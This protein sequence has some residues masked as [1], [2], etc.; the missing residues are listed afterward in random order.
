[1][2]RAIIRRWINEYLDGE[3]GLADKAE[4]E[5][6]MAENPE[7]HQEYKQL[8]RI[9]LYLSSIPDGSVHPT[10]FRLRMQK[11]LTRQEP[12][13]IT[14]QRAFAGAMVVALVV[15]A[16]TFG[17]MLYSQQ[18]A[19]IINPPAE[20]QVAAEQTYHLALDTG[21]TAEAFFNRLLL[22]SS[23]GMVDQSLVQPFLGQ[24]GVYEGAVCTQN[25]GMDCV[26]F[27]RKL[28]QTVKVR[29]TPRQALTLGK[30]AEGLTGREAGLA[31][32]DRDGAQVSLKD[33]I[34]F[35]GDNAVQLEMHFK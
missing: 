25:G 23:L 8:R 18:T 27:P 7:V 22:E 12:A 15:V 19:E 29:V 3:I 2:N 26:K 17:L 11:A 5:R 20:Q 31:V 34:Q 28:P 30:I 1:M 24:S 4:L 9:S 13:F 16:I 6:I 21:A 14:P 33:F 35:N 10:R 32:K